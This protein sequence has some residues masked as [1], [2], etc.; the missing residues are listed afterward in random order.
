MNNKLFV[1]G[2]LH[3]METDTKKLSKK[4]WKEQNELTKDDI[5]IQ[6]GDFG[7]IWYHDLHPKYKRDQRSLKELSDAPYTFC[8]V[9]GNHENFDLLYL[10]KDVEMFGSTVKEVYPGVYWLQRGHIYIIN[11]QKVFVMGGAKSNDNQKDGN[12]SGRGRNKKLKKQKVWWEQEIP[13]QEEF[14][15]GIQN[16]EKHNWNV[17]IVISHNCP[18]YIIQKMYSIYGDD[19]IN[20]DRMDDPVVQ[21]FDSILSKLTFKQWHFGHHHIDIN[22]DKFNCHYRNTPKELLL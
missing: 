4:N 7:Y 5:L 22:I 6:L 2:D 1:C 17:D 16:L 8:F 11:G 14:D 21:Y 20:I 18:S 15:L 9:D 10:A 13:S 19:E 12:Y 3:G